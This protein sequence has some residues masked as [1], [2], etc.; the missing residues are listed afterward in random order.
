MSNLVPPSEIEGIVGAHRH[1]VSHFGRAVSSEQT[2][3]ILHSRECV[4]SGVDLRDC[5]FSVALDKGIDLVGPEDFYLPT[6]AEIFEAIRVL[7]H[8]GSGVDAVTVPTAAT[9]PLYVS[10]RTPVVQPV[11]DAVPGPV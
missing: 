1:A 5:P 9:S 8:S 11:G 3:Y 6:H 4:D 10:I 7:H 2:V